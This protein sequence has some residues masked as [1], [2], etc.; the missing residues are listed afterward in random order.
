MIDL[1]FDI[2]ILSRILI[3]E[4]FGIEYI[5]L[6]LILIVHDLIK[7]IQRTANDNINNLI[8]F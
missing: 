7:N 5:F 4:P 1:Y 2:R 8:K 3:F 6:I